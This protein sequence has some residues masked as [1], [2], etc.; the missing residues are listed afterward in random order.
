[1]RPTPASFFGGTND[2]NTSFTNASYPPIMNN[3]EQMVLQ[4]LAAGILPIIVVPPCKNGYTMARVCRWFYY[5]LARYYS[6]PL[7]DAYLYW[8]NPA[9]DTWISGYTGDGVHPNTV[10]TAAAAPAFATVLKNLETSPCPPYLGVYSETSG[11][12]PAN[13]LQNGSF[14]S[15]T[16]NVPTGWTGTTTYGAFTSAAAA[17]PLAG[18]SVTF[19]QTSAGNANALVAPTITSGFSV[20]DTLTFSGNI[21]ITGITPATATGFTF[22]VGMN[23]A[24]GGARPFNGWQP[25]RQLHLLLRDRRVRRDRQ[26]A[27]VFQPRRQW[28][29]LHVEQPDL[30]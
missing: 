26:H 21:T 29:L 20:N 22:G 8:V 27:G 17:F 13:L 16:S 12:N 18:N 10:A 23:G 11:G 5:R 24:N 25:K 19:S 14:T 15:L 4:L 28:R 6:L 9:A 1:M 3:I 30:G 2:Y 7:F